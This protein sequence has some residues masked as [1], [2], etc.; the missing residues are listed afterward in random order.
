MKS[1]SIKIT[2]KEDGNVWYALVG[3]YL[4]E[5]AVGFEST[6]RFALI[7]MMLELDRKGIDIEEFAAEEE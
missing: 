5:G 4:E 1:K 7:E 6:A 3:K 2:L